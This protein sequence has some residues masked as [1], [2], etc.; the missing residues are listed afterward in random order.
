VDG[1]TRRGRGAG[2]RH[3]LARETRPDAGAGAS[4]YQDCVA[5]R[6]EAGPG[7]TAHE[8]SRPPSSVL[9]AAPA[10]PPRRPPAAVT[11]EYAYAAR[12]R[13]T[14]RGE[15][16]LS[17]H[18]SSGEGSRGRLEGASTSADGRASLPTR[19]L[20]WGWGGCSYAKPT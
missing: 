11:V 4:P 15:K 8:D 3:R 12:P 7:A 1:R 5:A 14:P 13:E 2:A 19:R 20:V 10:A 18:A 16:T 17:W 6:P 9:V